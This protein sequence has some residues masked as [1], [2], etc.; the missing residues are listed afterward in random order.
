MW[1]KIVLNLL[2]N[3]FKF[4]FE[5]QIKVSL[6][7]GPGCVELSV[8]D[9]GVGIAA[10]ELPR[11]FERF[12]RVPTTRSRTLEGTGIG[13][14]LVQELVTIHGGTIQAQ[15]VEG[16]GTTFTVS[17]PTGSAHLPNERVGARRSLVS[18]A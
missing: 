3:A 6:R 12:H 18:T 11:I 13:L 10:E 2:S 7:S 4:T 14:A 8:M 15:S 9:T 17:V 5:G 16:E 1:E